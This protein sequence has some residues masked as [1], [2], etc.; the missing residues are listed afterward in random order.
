MTTDEILW[1]SAPFVRECG[2]QYE[3]PGLLLDASNKGYSFLRMRSSRRKLK[4]E[5]QVI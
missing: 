1:S 4:E 5:A 3:G 2:E